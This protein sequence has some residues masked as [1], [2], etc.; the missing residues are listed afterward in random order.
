M[1]AFFTNYH[2]RSDSLATVRDAVAELIQTRAF[3]SPP[4]NGWV[5]IYDEDSDNQDEATLSRIGAGLSKSLKTA[6]LAVLVHSDI[7]A[8]WLYQNGKLLDEFN[9]AP[10][11]FEAT[12]EA[13]RQRLRGDPDALLPLCIAGTARAQVDSILHDPDGSPIMAEQIF[14]ELAPVLGIDPARMSLGFTYFEEEGKDFLPDIDQFEPVGQGAERKVAA[15]P[16]PAARPEGPLPDMYSVA[17]GMLAQ[18]WGAEKLMGPAFAAMLSGGLG[19]GMVKKLRAGMDRQA[20]ELMKHS[21]LQGGPTFEELKAARDGGPEQFAELL[22]RRTP[23]YLGDIGVQAVGAQAEQF[24]AA[25]LEHGLD[26]NAPDHNGQ[27]PL[28]VAERH[29]KDSKIHRLL[30]EAAER[31]G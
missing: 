27:T 28:S 25:L 6:T 16:Q 17:V 22:A 24:V 31:R 18:T 23:A 26:P 14:T 3:V 21:K 9:S 12:D 30:K 19:E 7:A 8:Y 1:G 13:T 29:A 10:D 11:Y 5:T 2:V 20:R 15:T 4:K